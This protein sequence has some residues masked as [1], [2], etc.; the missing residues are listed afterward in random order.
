MYTTA[1]PS[2]G[3]SSKEQWGALR[4][5]IAGRRS[6]IGALVE[7]VVVRIL[8]RKSHDVDVCVLHEFFLNTRG[9]NVYEI[10]ATMV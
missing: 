10:T 3:E 1:S 4:R 2:A 6:Q 7:L 8:L 5:L 9:R